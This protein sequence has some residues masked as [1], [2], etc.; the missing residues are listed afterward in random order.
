M[1]CKND[2]KYW[3]SDANIF[4][5]DYF[6]FKQIQLGYTLPADLTKKAFVQNARVFVSLDDFFTI[7]KYPG[8]DP[9][10][11]TT[12]N[13]DQMGIDLGSYPVSKKFI[14]GF[15]LTF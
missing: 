12:Q 1:R 6:K 15:S 7:S 11:A 2:T 10:T 9:E 8:M 14:F 5:G 4:K 3:A 13:A